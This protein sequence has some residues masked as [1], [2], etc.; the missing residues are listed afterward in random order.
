MTRTSPHLEDA[1]K[2]IELFMEYLGNLSMIWGME[3]PL[4]GGFSNWTSATNRHNGQ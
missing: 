2:P 1:E 4:L 3:K